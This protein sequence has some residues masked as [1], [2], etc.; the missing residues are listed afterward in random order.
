MS[1]VSAELGDAAARGAARLT[2]LTGRVWTEAELASIALESTRALEEK[3]ARARLADSGVVSLRD[4]RLAR[5][6]DAP[7]LPP[8]SVTVSV[9]LNIGELHQVDRV[10]V[11]LHGSTTYEHRAETLRAALTRGF[12]ALAGELGL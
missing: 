1:G 6:L 3:A 5:G 11:A 10:V 4:V 9:T 12:E 7:A 8:S 2:E